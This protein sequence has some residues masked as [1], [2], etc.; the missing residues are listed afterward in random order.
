MA[1]GPV[2]WKED[3]GGSARSRS[4]Q[5]P[6]TPRRKIALG[7]YIAAIVLNIAVQNY[8]LGVPVFLGALW[9]VLRDETPALRR[10]LGVLLACVAILTILQPVNSPNSSTL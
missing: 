1:A 9:F 7:L 5:L 8:W 4:L 2:E 3:A 10:R 6:L